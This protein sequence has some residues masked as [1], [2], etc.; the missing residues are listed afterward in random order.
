MKGCCLRA[1]ACVSGHLFGLTIRRRQPGYHET[2]SLQG[3]KEQAGW[4]LQT[5]CQQPWMS[6]ELGRRK[7]PTT[8]HRTPIK[9]CHAI[10]F[11]RT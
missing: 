6:L 10:K 1:A 8:T 11:L 5:S 9:T 7:W 2:L 3:V 4:R